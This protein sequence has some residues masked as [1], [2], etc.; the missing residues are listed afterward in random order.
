LELLRVAAQLH[1]PLNT[2]SSRVAVVVA[3]RN[4]QSHRQVVQEVQVVIVAT[5]QVKTQ[6]AVQ[7]LNLVLL[8]IQ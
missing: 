4:Q 6:V 2:W 7:L 1:Y 3:V 8:P 5:V